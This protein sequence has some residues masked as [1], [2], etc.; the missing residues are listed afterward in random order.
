MYSKTHPSARCVENR[1]ATVEHKFEELAFK[2]ELIRVQA[3]LASADERVAD[4]EKND[5]KRGR[6]PRTPRHHL[7]TNVTVAVCW[8]VM[9]NSAPLR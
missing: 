3:D 2:S 1:L 5:L 4:L 8:I 9:P 6:G 7:F